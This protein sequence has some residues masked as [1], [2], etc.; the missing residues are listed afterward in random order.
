MLL[1][2]PFLVPAGLYAQQTAPSRAGLAMD[3]TLITASAFTMGAESGSPSVTPAHPVQIGNAYYIG[4]YE[5]TNRQFCDVMNW[6]VEQGYVL[7][8]AGG[9]EDLS[10]TRYLGIGRLDWGEQLGIES[11]QGRLAPTQ[12]RADHPVAGVSWYG[13]AAFCNFLSLM[14]GESPAYDLATWRCSWDSAGYR[15][16]TEAEWELAARGNT[17]RRFPWGNMASARHA[18]FE[19]SGDPFETDVY[20]YASRGGPTTPVGYYDGSDRSGY[21]TLS[22][23]SVLGVQDMGGNVAEWCWD[24]YDENYYARSPRQDPKGPDQ[25][26][27]RTLRGGSW[28]W[29]AAEMEAFRRRDAEPG[30]C[31][32]MI[33][34]R[35]VSRF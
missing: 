26:P 23:A 18:N 12:G 7:V 14:E 24:G 11:R 13:A 8:S 20:P 22:G 35:V 15:L 9:V 21:A 34:F 31:G 17:G 33:G 4:T 3:M 25:T 32:Y 5:V 1:L 2:L 29:K 19:G 27:T 10:G 6:A 28:K 30:R 16:P